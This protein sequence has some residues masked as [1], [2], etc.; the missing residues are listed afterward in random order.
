MADTS[1]TQNYEHPAFTRAKAL[2][3]R[4][5]GMFPTTVAEAQS[6]S[7]TQFYYPLN[8]RVLA[9]AQTRIECAWSA[10]CDAVPGQNHRAEIDGV[11]NTGAKLPEHIA[12]AIFPRFE[13][14]PYAS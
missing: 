7:P 1:V 13:D 10:Y 14:V 11:L 3:E 2:P 6:W 9:V 5:R 4:L 12:R 8:S